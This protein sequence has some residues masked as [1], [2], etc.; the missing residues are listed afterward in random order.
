[1]FEL[2]TE[3]KPKGDQPEAIN[4]MVNSLLSGEKVQV[5]LGAT[6]TGKTFTIAK[7]IQKLFKELNL[8]R[9]CVLY[10]VNNKNLVIQTFKEI[11]SFF[12]KNKVKCYFSYF[13]YYR[14]EAYKPITDTYLGK[15]VQVNNEIMKMRIS[16]I[17]SLISGEDIIIVSSV[18]AIY[19]CISPK[20][21]EEEKFSLSLGEKTKEEELR[22]KF[23]QLGYQEAKGNKIANEGC[24]QIQEKEIIFSLPDN[25]KNCFF[26]IYTNKK[27]V[28]KI[29]KKDLNNKGHL[30]EELE[31]IAILPNGDHIKRNKKK[32]GKK[33]KKNKK[34]VNFTKK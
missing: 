21:Y 18:A 34:R 11:Q 20:V 16:T 13:D 5:L 8:K 33:R 4:K 15:K 14:P 3:L 2:V 6:G 30:I 27:T 1:M 26:C 17:N 12:P 24:F 22:E 25:T 28:V 23:L 29:E 31:K 32:G 7:I 19:G 9:N 10:L